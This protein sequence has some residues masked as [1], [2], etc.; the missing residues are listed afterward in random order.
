MLQAAAARHRGTRCATAAASL[1]PT[2]SRPEAV[3]PSAA[4]ADRVARTLVTLRRA[5]AGPRRTLAQAEKPG[6]Q[7][8]AAVR[9]AGA[10]RD[11]ASTLSDLP[12]R[13]VD[14]AAVAG[15]V[16]G[17]SATADVYGRL[18]AAARSKSLTEYERAGR[19]LAAARAQLQEASRAFARG[20]YE[21]R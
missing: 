5:V 11:A 6:E 1:R 9:L 3:G 10:Y 18:A 8:K 15:L 13:V 20:G 16:D 7:A 17:M 4:F 21:T 14:G 19:A 2:T 12:D